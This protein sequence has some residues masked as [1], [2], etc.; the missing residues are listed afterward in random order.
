MEDPASD[1]R[2]TIH[3]ACLCGA[4]EF[5]IELPVRFCAHCHCSMCR[6][7]HGAGF[8]TWAGV[9][10]PHFRITAGDDR[11]VRFRSSPEAWRSFCATCGSSLFFESERWSGEVHVAVANLDRPPRPPAAHVFYSDRVDWIT[12]DDHLPR[13]GGD[14]GVEPQPPAETG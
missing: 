6:R 12:V 1:E 10:H 8:V 13:F 9:L 4:V 3:G 7:A 2:G 14:S 11:L 5:E